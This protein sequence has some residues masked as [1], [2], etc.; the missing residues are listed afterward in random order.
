MTVVLWTPPIEYMASYVG[1]AYFFGVDSR[2]IISTVLCQK[3]LSDISSF[4]QE[5]QK[6]DFKQFSFILYF[7][8]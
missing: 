4:L 7:G 8:K 6:R 5:R 1:T 2:L 3:G